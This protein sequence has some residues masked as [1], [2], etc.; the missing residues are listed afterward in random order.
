[1]KAQLV[2]INT[3][4]TRSPARHLKAHH[5]VWAR[6]VMVRR[7]VRSDDSGGKIPWQ[8]SVYDRFQ[9]GFTPGA[10]DTWRKNS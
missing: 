6:S 4:Q 5:S 8:V 9:C 3:V 2:G 10:I 7:P 1:M